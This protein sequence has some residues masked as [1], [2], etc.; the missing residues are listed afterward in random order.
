MRSSQSA[1]M[2]KLSVVVADRQSGE[3]QGAIELI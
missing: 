2:I 3:H 1:M